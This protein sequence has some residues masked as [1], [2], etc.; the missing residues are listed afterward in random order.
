MYS[1]YMTL[2]N[3]SEHTLQSLHANIKEILV[4]C[5]IMNNDARVEMS[6]DAKYEPQGNGTEV[7]ML[8]FLQQNEISIED[9]LSKKSRESEHECSIPFSPIRKRMT[10][11][12]RPYKGCNY[13][14][15]VV[16]GAPE[17]VMKYCTKILTQDGETAELDENERQRILDDEIIGNFATKSGLRTFA[18]AYKDID[19]E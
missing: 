17:Y 7:A 10:T 15:V 1:G 19:S 16:K 3:N 9:L 4:D 8:R 13:V 11:V 14:R 18:Y 6:E 12:I 5:I 2:D